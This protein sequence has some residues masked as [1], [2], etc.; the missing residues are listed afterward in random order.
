MDRARLVFIRLSRH[1]PLAPSTV[2]WNQSS[3]R[4]TVRKRAEQSWCSLYCFHY[5]VHRLDCAA[6][7]EAATQV[8]TQPTT[9]KT[10]N[11]QEA[12]LMSIDG[13]AVQ[14]SLRDFFFSCLVFFSWRCDLA[15]MVCC[16]AP[17][18]L[19]RGSWGFAPLLAAVLLTLLLAGM[20][21]TTA[22]PSWRLEV[23]CDHFTT[24]RRVVSAIT[25]SY[26]LF[27]VSL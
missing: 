13:K 16:P 24:G 17:R 9:R 1:W 20:Q 27:G 26:V 15:V 21:Q 23:C 19:R 18:G 7:P 22:F 3:G 6:A 14:T 2:M 4:R 25:K 5:P 8:V 10:H 11:G 12:V